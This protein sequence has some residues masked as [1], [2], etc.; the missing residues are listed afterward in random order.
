MGS[1]SLKPP[2]PPP[3]HTR[4]GGR[5]PMPSGASDYSFTEPITGRDIWLNALCVT[6]G[7]I[8]GSCITVMVINNT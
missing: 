6:L 1:P 8:A 4:V 7:A 3:R 2:I 5:P